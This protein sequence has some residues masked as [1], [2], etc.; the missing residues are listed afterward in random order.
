MASV[1]YIYKKKF[2]KQFE[3]KVR[4]FRDKFKQPRH[5]ETISDENRYLYFS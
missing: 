1:G 2:S 3:K 4:L 5:S